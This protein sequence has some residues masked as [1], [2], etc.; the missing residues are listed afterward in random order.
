MAGD[1]RIYPP[2]SPLR[3]GLGAHCPRCGKGRLFRG[4]LTLAPACEVCGLDFSFADAADG[5]AFFVMAIVGFVVVGGALFVEIKWQP[6]LWVHVAL[7]LPLA[8]ALPLALLRP[9][10]GVMVALQYRYR[11]EEGRH[12]SDVS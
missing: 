11:A 7:W 6:P 5:P 2:V 8:I 4:F 1:D 9:F 12:A 10:K 3:A